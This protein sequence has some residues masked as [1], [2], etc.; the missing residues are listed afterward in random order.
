MEDLFIKLILQAKEGSKLISVYIDKDDINKFNAGLVKDIQEDMLY[1]QSYD[2]N[3]FEDGVIVIRLADIY[4]LEYGNKYLNS[5]EKVIPNVE[6][7]Q[8]NTKNLKPG[9]NLVETLKTCMKQKL[10]TSIK[11]VYSKGVTGYIKE[12]DDESVL[13]EVITFDAEKDGINCVAIGDIE[14]V[15]FDGLDERRI[16]F[17]LNK[18]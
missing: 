2:P 8:K 10:I 17:L 4:H 7:I 16:S 5:L 3:G 15:Y 11:F 1:L 12:V 18:D 9:K 14:R 13:I 6:K